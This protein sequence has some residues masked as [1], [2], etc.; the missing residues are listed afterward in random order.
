M[1]V[2]GNL[3]VE[4]LCRSHQI[5]PV[6][7]QEVDVH[8]GEGK[9][10]EQVGVHVVVAHQVV[11]VR[12]VSYEIRGLVGQKVSSENDVL[13]RFYCKLII[14]KRFSEVCYYLKISNIGFN[15]HYIV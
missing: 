15:T 13:K 5:R 8:A 10:H 7:G 2:D 14:L 11:D 4:D 1:H 6:H 9:S 12:R 3:V